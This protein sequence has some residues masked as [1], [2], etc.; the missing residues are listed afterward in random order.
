[1]VREDRQATPASP[2]PQA[3]HSHAGGS[4]TRRRGLF[5]RNC[6]TQSRVVTLAKMVGHHRGS[7]R[8]PL[9]SG[10]ASVST[11]Q[12]RNPSIP[13]WRWNLRG[14]NRRLIAVS[15]EGFAAREPAEEIIARIKRCAPTAEVRVAG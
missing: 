13:D 12:A 1:P 3:R 15:A 9:A 6:P 10:R 5:R 2:L 7:S 8:F 11:Y 14:A 4:R